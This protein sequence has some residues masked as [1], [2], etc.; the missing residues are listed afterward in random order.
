MATEEEQLITFSAVRD[1]RGR[2]VG[3]V[4]GSSGLAAVE[5]AVR[6]AL[7]PAGGRAARRVPDRGVG[8]HVRGRWVRHQEAAHS[9]LQGGTPASPTASPMPA[10]SRRPWYRT[11]RYAEVFA[12]HFV[13]DRPK[14]VVSGDHWF[15][16]TG[17]D[18]LLRGRGGLH[19]HGL[20]GL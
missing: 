14:D 10:A 18:T 15:H 4:S 12:D 3:L 11:H 8:A 16:R 17:P 5:H 19:R 6:T 9:D 20:P 7:I 13:L 2:I 1:G